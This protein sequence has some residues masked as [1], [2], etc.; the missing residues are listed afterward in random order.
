VVAAALGALAPAGRRILWIT[1]LASLALALALSGT[2]VVIGAGL[3]C[4]GIVLACALAPL[5]LSTVAPPELRLQLP[6]V[7]GAFAAAAALAAQAS[8]HVTCPSRALPHLL[9]FHVAGVVVAAFLGS[10]LVALRRA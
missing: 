3:R 8:L 6:A 9:G 10:R 7:G 5:A 2:G 1:L 4:L